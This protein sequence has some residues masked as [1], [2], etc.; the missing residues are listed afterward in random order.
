MSQ[1]TTPTNPQAYVHNDA[2]TSRFP[3][4]DVHSPFA[5]ENYNHSTNN[6]HAHPANTPNTVPTPNYP[7][8]SYMSQASSADPPPSSQPSVHSHSPVSHLSNSHF[9]PAAPSPLGQHRFPPP[10]P[11]STPTPAP[12]PAGFQISH[13]ARDLESDHEID[14][15]ESGSIIDD[16]HDLDLDT[17]DWNHF[18]EQDI[19]I[20]SASPSVQKFQ[21]YFLL[22]S[23][24]TVLMPVLHLA[25]IIHQSSPNPSYS[26]WRA[27]S[28][29]YPANCA[30]CSFSTS[31]CV[32]AVN[33]RGQ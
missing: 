17:Q 32:C 3:P 22:R 6:T 25:R 1:P 10:S 14:G 28:S 9:V 7:P 29:F 11:Q 4:H 33:F 16:E 20:S 23:I 2:S 21:V 12:A 24:T 31:P 30:T 18:G 26:Q 15:S 19:G 5:H 13:D 27:H 8:P